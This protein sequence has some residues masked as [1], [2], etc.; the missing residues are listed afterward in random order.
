MN[1]NLQQALLPLAMLVFLLFAVPV[2]Y[3]D[4]SYTG[5]GAVTQ[6][7]A[8]I[9]T[10][11]LFE[12][13]QG[14]ARVAAVGEISDIDG[15]VWT[16]PA[17]NQ[18]GSATHAINMY[19]DCSGYRPSGISEVDTDRVPVVTVDADGDVITGYI[20]ADNY[21]E[22]YING[23]LIAVDGVPFTPFN[24]SIVKFKVKRPYVIAF[25]AIDWEEHLGLG[26]E[27][28][29]GATYA[30]GDGGLIASFSDGTVTS[31]DWNAQTYY[32]APVYDL[33]CLSEKDGARL[34]MDCS[35][36]GTNSG[37]DAYGVHWPLP[38]GWANESFNASAWPQATSYTEAVIGVDN[39][40]GYMNFV[41]LF[42][43]AGASFIW[44]SNVILDNEVLL[45]YRV[46]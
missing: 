31:S 23:Q 4:Y 22:L 8:E 15:K 39:K 43:G 7:A 6:G 9:I 18:Y 41:E 21:F 33:S 28:G 24:S 14:R 10:S 26:T 45:R 34:S 27:R 2:T 1:T 5:T 25:K 12:C 38:Q 37:A 36:G 16:V 42:T 30:A 17:V 19:D 32:V 3:G 35:T 40:N 11:S 44:T 20:F 13:V 29:R 46:E